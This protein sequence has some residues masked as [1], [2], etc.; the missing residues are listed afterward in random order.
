MTLNAFHW[1]QQ[2]SDIKT[3]IV[4]PKAREKP[5]RRRAVEQWTLDG[6]FV[7]RYRSLE[8][9]GRALGVAATNICRVCNGTRKSMHGF[10][11]KYADQAG[12]ILADRHC[13]AFS[14]AHAKE[15]RHA[16]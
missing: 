9:A 5:G 8:E 4:S 2:T 12:E 6:Q 7:A 16:V 14:K 1:R 3:P 11:W 15:Q 13:G 10:R